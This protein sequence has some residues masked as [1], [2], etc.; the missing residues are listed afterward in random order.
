MNFAIGDITVLGMAAMLAVFAAGLA[1]LLWRLQRY[2]GD[3][4]LWPW[5]F[6]LGNPAMW[7]VL[8]GF[9][10]DLGTASLNRVT[11]LL[12]WGLALVTLGYVAWYAAVGW[13]TEKLGEAHYDHWELRDDDDD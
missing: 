5:I 1:L 11:D 4:L 3:E 2:P 6:A 10:V 13:R 8:G 9:Q 12:C 7:E